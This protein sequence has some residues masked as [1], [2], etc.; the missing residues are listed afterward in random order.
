M[1]GSLI[2]DGKALPYELVP[3]KDKKRF[4]TSFVQDGAVHLYVPSGTDK[5]TA[6]G[7]LATRFYDHYYKLHPEEWHVV[8]YLGTTYH[9]ECRAGKKTGVTLEGDRMIIRATKESTRAYRAVLISFFKQTVEREL[10][11]L[12]YDAQNDF[13]EIVFPTVTDKSLRGYLGYNYG[14][15]RVTLSPQIA[16]FERRFLRALL[17]HELCHSLVRGHGEDFWATLEK[18][19]PGAVAM[20]RE[21]HALAYDGKDY[22]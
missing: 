2:R 19:L 10:V 16:R 18:K 9:A 1:T 5:R 15:G 14:D 8:H 6:E 7:V 21:R 3:T 22:I 20:E 13:S 12:M 11:S 4:Y 17:Y